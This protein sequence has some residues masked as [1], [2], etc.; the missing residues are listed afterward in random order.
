MDSRFNHRRA[1]VHAAELLRRAELH[2]LAAR[3]R[4]PRHGD[5]TPSRIGLILSNL[6]RNTVNRQKKGQLGDNAA[7]VLDAIAAVE[8]RDVDRLFSLYHED[9]E[10]HDA[11]SLPY[12]GR[13]R[14]K[15]VMRR[16]LEE[17]PESTWL[18][19]WGP[20][21]PT[22]RE[23]RMDPRVIAES[24]PEVVVLYRQRALDSSGGRLDAPCLGLY[25]VRG[26]KF[27]RAQMFHFDTAAILGFLANGRR[28]AG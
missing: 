7:V 8:E 17:D 23:R 5:G 16:E 15:Q 28:G 2:R 27:A 25:E 22:E 13:R 21:Q 4:R 10:F 6:W 14:G 9:V 1:Q 20:L 11:P 26:G 24:G 3:A 19:T 12:G 18:G